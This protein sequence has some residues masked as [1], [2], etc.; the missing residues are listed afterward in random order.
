MKTIFTVT[1]RIFRTICVPHPRAFHLPQQESQRMNC[2][3]RLQSNPSSIFY[4]KNTVSMA[5]LRSRAKQFA[6]NA[7]KLK[8]RGIT[9]V[10]IL[11]VFRTQNPRRDCVCYHGI[12]GDSLPPLHPNT[13]ISMKNL[14][15]LGDQKKYGHSIPQVQDSLSHLILMLEVRVDWPRQ[16]TR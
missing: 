16:C 8:K 14:I 10:G 4:L 6:S 2:Y 3:L 5:R 9:T 12:P 15:S 11:D 1:M 7:V 13:C